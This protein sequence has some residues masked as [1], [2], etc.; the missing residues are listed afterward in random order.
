VSNPDEINIK[1]ERGELEK[2]RCK[3]FKQVLNNQSF[4]FHNNFWSILY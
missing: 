2:M 4:K 1:Y 3:G